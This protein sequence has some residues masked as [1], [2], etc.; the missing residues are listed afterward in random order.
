MKTEG[1][2]NGE[3]LPQGGRL[4]VRLGSLGTQEPGSPSAGALTILLRIALTARWQ[5]AA[6]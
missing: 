5:C 6:Q 2:P 1:G 3:A 4:A